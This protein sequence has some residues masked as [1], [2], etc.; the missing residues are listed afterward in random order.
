VQPVGAG[1]D[2]KT[3]WA[4]PV[5]FLVVTWPPASRRSVVTW[6]RVGPNTR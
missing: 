2:P 5:Q 4:R 1:G 6:S 3:A